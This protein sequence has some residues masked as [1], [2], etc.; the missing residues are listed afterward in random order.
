MLSL[1]LSGLYVAVCL[2]LLL[3]VLLQ[4]GKGGDMAAAT[5][6][7]P[8]QHPASM[9]C[10]GA[11]NT[12]GIGHANE[13]PL[14]VRKIEVIPAQRPRHPARNTDERGTIDIRSYLIVQLVM[15]DWILREA[16]CAVH[17]FRN[18]CGQQ[19]PQSL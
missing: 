13:G 10:P 5:G 4:Q 7:G 9:N 19:L 8:S 6:F 17:N 12:L 11:V 18:F 14:V 1:L 3:V 16:E 15:D 2:L